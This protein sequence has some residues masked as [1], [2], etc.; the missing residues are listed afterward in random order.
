MHRTQVIAAARHV[1]D[2]DLAPSGTTGFSQPVYL[3]TIGGTPSIRIPVAA[4]GGEIIQGA[5]LV[6]VIGDG[7][8]DA[9]GSNAHPPFPAVTDIQMGVGIFSAADA[10]NQ[11][12]LIRL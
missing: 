5:D 8:A 11:S 10:A 3:G 2:A 12:S 9:G 7:G 4:T 6:V 1:P